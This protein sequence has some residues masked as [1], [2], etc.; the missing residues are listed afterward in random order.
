MRLVIALPLLL[1]VQRQQH[2]AD[3]FALNNHKAGG[4][5]TTRLESWSGSSGYLEH[6][7]GPEEERSVVGEAG[8]A[9]AHQDPSTTTLNHDNQD[10]YQEAQQYQEQLQ[11]QH[12]EWAYLAEYNSETATS[13]T[14]QPP[15][16]HPNPAEHPVVNAPLNPTTNDNAQQH[17]EEYSYGRV[18][19]VEV[20]SP[21]EQ[22]EQEVLMMQQLREQDLLRQ[23]EQLQTEPPQ[24][25]LTLSPE[26]EAD[27]LEQQRLRKLYE[28]QQIEKFR[29]EV[30]LEPPQEAEQQQQQQSPTVT[31]T[32]KSKLSP[33]EL[34]EQE[35]FL[36]MVSSEIQVK[37]LLGQNTIPITEIPVGTALSR[38]VDTLEDIAV[39]A[40]RWPYKNG[41]TDM[42]D[43]QELEQQGKKK[44]PTIVVLGTGWA[45]NSFS[46]VACTY[47]LKLI[48][49]SPVN[50]FVRI[51]DV[52][53]C[54]FVRGVLCHY[55]FSVWVVP[56]LTQECMHPF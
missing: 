46:K 41:W 4:A 26:E 33:E 39:L 1:L 12:D 8:V 20:M 13:L 10:Y 15:A 38:T 34:Q 49:V 11:R 14:E 40:R 48:I 36:N 19:P 29:G 43:F 37:K 56:E 44:R 22:F 54:S 50:H 32:Q 42:P 3:A 51:I 53:C 6:L 17:Q 23:H 24:Q 30:I 27:A 55:F 31:T 45:A 7:N 35:A 21:E 18:Q 28:E 25:Q 5:K 2:Q 52:C 47:D 16:N 9:P